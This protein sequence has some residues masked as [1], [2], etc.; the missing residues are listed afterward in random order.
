MTVKYGVQFKSY[1]NLMVR[2]KIQ[3]KHNHIF[4]LITI[5]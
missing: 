1:E 5:N 4:T 3:D 2:E